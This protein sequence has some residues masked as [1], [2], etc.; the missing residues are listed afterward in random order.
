MLLFFFFLEDIEL[1]DSLVVFWPG[2]YGLTFDQY[3][4]SDKELS[5][6]SVWSSRVIDLSKRNA[7]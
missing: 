1:A 4:A 3:Y 7:T 5:Y 2:H 6:Y